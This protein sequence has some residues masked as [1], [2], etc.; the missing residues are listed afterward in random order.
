LPIPA[1]AVALLLLAA[2][3]P[4]A[5][6]PQGVP[7]LAEGGAHAG[8]VLAIAEAPSLAAALERAA[9][10][11]GVALAE[12]PAGR[13]GSHGSLGE[14]QA[15]LQEEHAAAEAALR[16]G[17]YPWPAALRVARALENL[18]PW[19]PTTAQGTGPCDVLD[20]RPLLC[21]S[22]EGPHAHADEAAIVLD[23]GGDDAWTGR[24]GGA[25]M[26]EVRIAV[27]LAGR[28]TYT[29]ALDEDGAAQGSALGHGVGL[30]WD[31]S[32]DDT[33][34]CSSTGGAARVACHG[35]AVGTGLGLLL[36]GAGDD[37]YST[38]VE[39]APMVQGGIASTPDVVVAAQGAAANP[40]HRV[41]HPDPL[42]ALGTLQHG[43]GVLADGGGHDTRAV[44]VTTGFDVA[45]PLLG[46]I[47]G[48][49]VLA[50]QG[51]GVLGAGLLAD[52]GDGRDSTL[53]HARGHDMVCAVQGA[54]LFVGSGALVDAGGDDAY[55]ATCGEW[56]R[57]DAGP[58][59]ALA[60][61]GNHTSALQG[62]AQYGLLLRGVR[63]T[64]M[65]GL[66]ADLGGH[67]TYRAHA[68]MVAEARSA[69][70]A[71]AITQVSWTAAQGAG[72]E[73]DALLLDL[74]GDDVRTLRV[75][76]RAHASSP[77][78]SAKADARDTYVHGQG[79]AG[80]AYGI[81][82]DLGG[83]DT[84]AAEV[85]QQATIEGRPL[86]PNPGG[87]LVQPAHVGV[88]GAG[89]QR[90]QSSDQ[91]GLGLLLDVD[92]GAPDTVASSPPE[93]TCQPPIFPKENQQA[94]QVVKDLQRDAPRLP[95]GGPRGSALWFD[96]D[97]GGVGLMV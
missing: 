25:G 37:T 63:S 26:G 72:L 69:V 16:A 97:P 95:V 11:Q 20:H 54:G 94:P 89:D 32:G 49:V 7:L 3:V 88:Q 92:G 34:A 23:L 42:V 35:A 62:S 83:S 66:L 48:D 61:G 96:C 21:V 31:R 2:S 51:A 76:K 87:I 90:V 71:E 33:Y 14:A 81:L 80:Y 1:L 30:L 18:L 78:G 5:S 65:A 85:V 59:S 41:F 45:P 53:A 52:A 93:A 84:Y 67:D 9:A 77:Q 36:D 28:D 46:G 19:L 79:A 60:L 6:P 13:P 17:A 56:L 73:G 29:S 12:A 22:G 70:R 4:A 75:E 24:S 40:D 47:V 64:P 15:H 10:A 43:W 58:R 86:P 39:P 8:R 38:T 44:R 57:L 50:A 82:A 27:D 74:A 91:Q 68:A 55:D